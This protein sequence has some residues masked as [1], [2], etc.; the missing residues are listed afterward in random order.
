MEEGS[1]G[2]VPARDSILAPRPNVIGYDYKITDPIAPDLCWAMGDV[3]DDGATVAV[4]ERLSM[5]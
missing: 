1:G 2:A 4:S 5:P 3:T